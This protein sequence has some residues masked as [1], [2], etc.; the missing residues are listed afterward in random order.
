MFG[1]E[2]VRIDAA[3][4]K[5]TCDT[6]D[7][8]LAA[9]E[10]Y[11]LTT[12]QV[13]LSVGSW[14]RVL[15]KW[16]AQ[17]SAL[18]RGPASDKQYLLVTKTRE[19]TESI[20]ESF[21]RV[22]AK[23]QRE[24]SDRFSE[25]LL[26]LSIFQRAASETPWVICERCAAMF[27]FEGRHAREALERYRRTGRSQNAEPVLKLSVPKTGGRILVESRD[28]DICHRML[29]AIDAALQEEPRR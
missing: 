5:Y 20:A 27:T 1:R 3:S 22:A 12:K 16:K 23:L 13:V 10:G 25:N 8:K 6:C 15:F 21:R 17:C 14:R 24:C 2:V 4:D 9:N 11:L 7:G 18:S 28:D 19:S 26:E 29:K